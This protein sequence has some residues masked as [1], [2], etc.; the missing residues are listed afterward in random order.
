MD[1]TSRQLVGYTMG[2]SAADLGESATA[3]TVDILFDTVACAVAGCA[4]EPAAIVAQLAVKVGSTAGATVF[5]QDFKTSPEMAALANAMM[6]RTY[7][8][9]DAYYGHPSD[10][11]PGIL[12]AGEVAHSSGAQVLGAIALA[13]EIFGG[14][15]RSAPYHLDS[16]LDQGVFM[17]VAVALAAGKLWGLNESQLA[18]A[19]S[20][21]LVPNLPL[22]VVRWG[23]LSMMKGGATAFAVRNG[24]FAAML[25]RKGFTSSPDPYEGLCGLH[26]AIGAFELRLPFNTDGL[27]VVEMAYV[28]P[29]PSENNTIGLLEL[30]PAI[31]EWT[32]VDAI[33]SIDI[34]LATGLDVHLADEPKYDPKTRE[35]AD[36]SLPFVLARALVDGEIT[37]DTYTPQRIADPSI[38]PL[39]RKIHVRG[40]DE[41]KAIMRASRGT[42]AK[43]ARIKVTAGGKEFVREI[44]DH[45]GHPLREAGARRQML[46]RKL[47]LC[48][49]HAGLP[50]AQRERIRQAWWAVQDAQDIGE[51]VSTLR[52]RG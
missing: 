16:W 45:S 49:R 40:S 39:M 52:H 11:I 38:R 28:K 17:N 9:N 14:L 24:V 34:E 8:Y 12:A 25:A 7:D 48:A 36:H 2:F 32:A 50:D 42:E 35:S 47:D 6:V 23:E 27:R 1:K 15:A 19:A 13:Y 4:S 18:H 22:G 21:A 37:L 20:L 51:L 41:L 33:D 30:A 46:D 26:A 44:R 29:L 3:K 43:P 31:R 5:G 10:M